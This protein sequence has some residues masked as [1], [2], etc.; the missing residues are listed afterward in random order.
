MLLLLLLLLLLLWKILKISK[1]SQIIKKSQGSPLWIF[2]EIFQ[3]FKKISNNGLL[4]KKIEYYFPY[5]RGGGQRKYGNFHTFFFLNPSQVVLKL[6]F[7]PFFRN[8]CPTF[9]LAEQ[10]WS[11][12]PRMRGKNL[13]AW[14]KRNK[15]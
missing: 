11:M 2:C 12:C 9:R 3:N 1:K 15:D 5:F 7:Q 13:A 14:Q 6:H 8:V 10:N 4:L